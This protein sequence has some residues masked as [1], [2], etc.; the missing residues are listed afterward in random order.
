MCIILI[1]RK[2]PIGAEI[3]ENEVSF[4]VWAPKCKSIDVKIDD[5]E[6]YSLENEKNGYFSGYF[7]NIKDNSLYQYIV[8][9]GDA[10]PDPASRL[11]PEGPHGPSQII[12]PKKFQWSDSEWKGVTDKHQVILY[13]LHVGTFTKEGTWRAAMDKLP[14]LREL[15]VTV[16]EMM[17]IA[18]YPGKFNWGYDGVALFAP[19]RN[20]GSPEDLRAFVNEAHRLDLAVILDVVYNHLGPAGNYLQKYSD[21]YFGVEEGEWGRVL[22]FDGA[23]SASVRE[24]FIENAGY[25]IDEYHFDGLRLD[26]C[27]GIKDRST[28][29]ILLEI[30]KKVREKGGERKTYIVAENEQQESYF[31]PD[32]NQKGYQLDAVWAE[33]FHH[34]AY[35]RLTGRREAYFSD[36]NGQ[37]HEFVSS[38]KF[39]LLYQ[40]QW[41]S[42]QNKKRGT[43]ALDIS[44]F[45]FI[46]FLENHDQVANGG[47]AKRLHSLSQPALYRAMT[48]LLFLAPQNPLLFQ[49]QEFAS[50]SNFY[51]FCDHEQKLAKLINEGRKNF[52]CQFASITNSKVSH[53]IPLPNEESTFHLSK[54]DWDDKERHSEILQMQKDLIQLRKN[55]KVFSNLHEAYIQVSALTEHFFLLRYRV[56]GEERLLLFNLGADYQINPFSDPLLAPPVD[57]IWEIHWSSEFPEYGGSGF[58]PLSVEPWIITGNCAYLLYPKQPEL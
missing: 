5:N 55:D 54:L 10:Y 18:E 58:R 34:A 50:T 31:V 56:R 44:P 1:M 28:P 23:H 51:Y 33:D 47:N 49:G 9:N 25:W 14:Y 21:Y 30:S 19:T 35:V 16:L 7:K 12:D 3:F 45:H 6:R 57:H 53:R 37:A 27:H 42:W 41:Y 11:Q 26:A 29:H 22:N 39:N 2:M 38:L 40:G 32:E 48:T 43:P 46:I 20:Y 24:F 52:M 8:D 36:Y 15:G 4:R 17:P 13:E